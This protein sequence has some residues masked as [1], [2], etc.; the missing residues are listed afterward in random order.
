MKIMTAVNSKRIVTLHD[1]S[2]LMERDYYEFVSLPIFNFFSHIIFVLYMQYGI[3]NSF[4]YLGESCTSYQ[5]IDSESLATKRT[6]YDIREGVSAE[7]CWDILIRGNVM[8]YSTAIDKT[9]CKWSGQHQISLYVFHKSSIIS[10]KELGFKR[11]YFFYLLDL[12]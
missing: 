4:K 10:L 3:S 2:I 7:C 8:I 12:A 5:V 11:R 1:C 6:S 9:W